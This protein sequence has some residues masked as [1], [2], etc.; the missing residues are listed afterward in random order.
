MIEGLV[1]THT[2]LKIFGEILECTPTTLKTASN[3]SRIRMSRATSKVVAHKWQIATGAMDGRKTNTILTTTKPR[4]VQ[5]ASHVRKRTGI[6]RTFTMKTKEG[7]HLLLIVYK[8]ADLSPNG[9]RNPDHN[10]SRR[11]RTTL[12]SLAQQKRCPSNPSP[13]SMDQLSWNLTSLTRW[14]IVRHQQ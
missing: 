5:T 1:F 4:N 8:G 10:W 9:L 14:L 6:V 12:M 3:G 13:I 11:S 2:M 7:T